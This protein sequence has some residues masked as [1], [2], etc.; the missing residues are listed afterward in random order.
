MV[1]WTAFAAWTGLN[2]C[3]R[4][5]IL[6]D[7]LREGGGSEGPVGATRAIGASE[8]LKIK[9]M[10]GGEF[11]GTSCKLDDRPVLS[12][13][14]GRSCGCSA[15]FLSWQVSSGRSSPRR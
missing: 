6:V 4:T 2:S 10:V 12:V 14:V 11:P 1:G 3:A 8:L 13:P 9:E 15:I 5:L 7:A